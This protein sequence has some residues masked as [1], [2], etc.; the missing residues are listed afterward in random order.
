MFCVTEVQATY[1]AG[2]WPVPYTLRWEG[3]ILSIMDV[4]RRWHASDGIHVLV[5]VPDGSVFELHTNGALWR[6][7]RISHP[8][9]F[10]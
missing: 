6:A 2:G 3:Q 8:P 1:T 9:Y 4:G 5:R 7:K 10:A